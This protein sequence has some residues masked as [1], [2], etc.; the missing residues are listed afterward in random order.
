MRKYCL[1]AAAVALSMS[2]IAIPTPAS[3]DY[4]EFKACMHGCVEAYGNN[5]YLYNQCVAR[6]ADE[7][8]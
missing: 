1:R 3:A 5:Q 6:C 4:E 7:Y 8:G 2:G